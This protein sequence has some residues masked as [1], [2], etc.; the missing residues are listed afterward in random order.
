MAGVTPPG[1]FGKMNS[2]V[3]CNIPL[4]NIGIT[5][6]EGVL[7]RNVHETHCGDECF[8]T[9]HELIISVGANA[10]KMKGSLVIT[11]KEYLRTLGHK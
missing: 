10:F 2:D 3:I 6:V 9:Q 5:S 8:T 7:E 1:A 11:R 4:V